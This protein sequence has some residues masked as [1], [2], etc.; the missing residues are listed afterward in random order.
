MVLFYCND[1][2]RYEGCLA[3]DKMSRS[4]LCYLQYSSNLP[5]IT[6]KALYY[7]VWLEEPLFM[8][9]DALY[10]F[11]ECRLCLTF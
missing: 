6:L 11:L 10:Y 9:A 8:V 4:L 5:S 1:M 3:A 2:K 7:F